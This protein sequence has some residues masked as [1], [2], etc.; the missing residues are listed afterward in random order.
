MNARD[1]ILQ[2]IRDGLSAEAP[3]ELPPVP[4]VWPRTNPSPE[5][6]VERFRRELEAVQ[7]ELI[8]CGSMDEA[9]SKLADLAQQAKWSVIGAADRPMCRELLAGYPSDRTSWAK[10]GWD[11]KQIAELSVG[12]VAA[13][14]L[15][16]DTGTCLVANDTAEERLLCYLPATCVV[17]GRADQMAEHLPDAWEDVARHTAEPDRRGEFVLIT[18]PS[19]T[20]DIEKILI[21]GVHGPK[22]LVVVLVG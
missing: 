18:G 3:V 9:R 4:A 8:R 6:R 7:G 10:Q 21:L 15:L 20:A 2:R 5:Q 17:V 16:A 19:R 12:L 13:E 1:A 14:S 11:P 22:R